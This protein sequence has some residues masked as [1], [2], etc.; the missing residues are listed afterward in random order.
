M[1]QE[2][3]TTNILLSI[4]AI[5]VLFIILKQ[6]AFIFVPLVSSLFI[7]SLFLPI[8]R[9]LNKRNI[10]KYISVII[11]LLIVFG[12]IK[13]GVEL[14]QLTSREIVATKDGFLY[15]ASIKLVELSNYVESV[16]GIKIDISKNK[17]NELIAEKNLVTT[18]GFINTVLTR[19]LMTTFFVILWL[20]ESI[21]IQKLMNRTILKQERT[22]IKTFIKIEKD[23]ITFIKVKFT[24]SLFTGI[25]IGLA[26]YFFGISFPLFW[27]L[28]AFLVN[29]IQMIGSFVSVILLSLFAFV[30]LEVYSTLLFFI[31]TITA[32]Q[33]ILGAIFEPIFM[34]KS[35]SINVIAILISLMFWGYIW[36]V[37][38]LI[39]AI[40][41]TVFIK[42]ISE[43]F[44]ST[45]IVASL[46][47]GNKRLT[48]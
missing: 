45:K 25:G 41:I 40:P 21:N 33:V 20:V 1:L 10:P 22:S 8:M 23:L 24:I 4:I 11:V 27:G 14:I 38:G 46:L 5:P 44:E 39:L 36:G 17:F 37:V 34:G 2:R 28:F 7:A 47:S 3:R 26:C 31:L 6:L 29:F 32:V 16:F 15:K 30:E 9:W 48:V 42:I 43:Q 18:L 35:F 12:A 13:I 19:A